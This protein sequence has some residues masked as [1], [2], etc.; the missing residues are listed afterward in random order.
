[1][2]VEVTVSLPRGSGDVNV[3]S[4]QLPIVVQSGERAGDVVLRTESASISVGDIGAKS[5]LVVSQSGSVTLE[6]SSEQI[7]DDFITVETRSGGIKC[8]SSLLSPKLM[9][10]S[11]S[12]TISTVA[13]TNAGEI[14]IK[15]G[16][17]S[18]NADLDLMDVASSDTAM[19]CGSGSV[20]AKLRRWSGLVTAQSKS[21]SRSV[22][23][24]GVVQDKDGG[25][26]WHKGSGD[27]KL[28]VTTKSGSIKV[29]L[30]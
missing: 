20:S 23:G 5:L 14:R 21:G 19:E 8:L 11:Q 17:G 10:Q 28:A 12:G 25:G 9:V 3:H 29:E 1:M 13:A 16:S 27:A 2:Y 6:S 7:A 4:P 30:L 24:D 22:R 26:G 18:I 15:N